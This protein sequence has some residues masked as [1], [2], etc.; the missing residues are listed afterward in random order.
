MA[1]ETKY[2][3]TDLKR[4]FPDDAA[5]ISFVFDT[6][7]T[8]ECSCGGAYKLIEGRKQFQCSRCRYQIAPAVGT[9]FEKS[10]TPLSLW[11]H[12]IWIFSNAKSGVSGK[13]MERQLGVTYKCAWRILAEIRKALK[14]DGTKLRGDVEIDSTHFGGRF[15]S[16]KENKRQKEAIAS[17]AIVIGA[18]ERGGNMKAEIILKE[19]S[20]TVAEF[21]KKNIDLERSSLLTDK[22]PGFDEVSKGYDRHSI[23]HRKREYARGSIHINTIETFWAHLKRSVK[24][25]YKVISKRHLQSYLDVFVWHHNNRHNDRKRFG[26][27]L[28]AVLRPAI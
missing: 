11:F 22:S 5:C 20:E 7:H 2:S 10:A 9:I 24:G 26:S 8:R 4:D 25:T 19:N 18:V 17:K 12:A 27:L 21:V 14:Q 6:L 13:E 28:D 1:K 15:R 3:L 23:T 16:G